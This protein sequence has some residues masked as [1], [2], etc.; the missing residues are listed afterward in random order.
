MASSSPST[1]TTIDYDPY[2]EAQM[3]RGRGRGRRGS[4]RRGQTGR[5]RGRGVRGKRTLR[6]DRLDADRRAFLEEL[7]EERKRKAHEMVESLTEEGAKNI[8]RKAAEKVP[9]LLLDVADE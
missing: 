3:G 7:R 5:G 6:G 1:S 4:G 2:E 8:L 9:A